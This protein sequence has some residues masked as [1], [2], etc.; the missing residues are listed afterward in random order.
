MQMTRANRRWLR[1][2]IAAGV[3]VALV[4]VA[5][6]VL[7]RMIRTKSVAALAN[8]CGPRS[9]VTMSAMEVNV[10]AGDL[11]WTRVRVEQPT[12]SLFAADD[13][14]AF[15]IAGTIDTVAIEG[16]SLFRLIF[17]RSFVARSLRI[18]HPDLHV[19]LRNDTVLE[20]ATSAG[21]RALS[22]LRIM[23]LEID[24]G[25]LHVFRKGDQGTVLNVDQFA[26]QATGAIADFEEGNAPL[27]QF[28]T[29]TGE[30]SDFAA[31]LS[32]LYDMRVA[33]V[34]LS[35]GGS[36][37][38]VIGAALEPLAGPENYGKLVPFETDLI[39]MHAD[40]LLAQGLDINAS[41]AQRGLKS[42]KLLMAGVRGEVHRDKTL[43]DAPYSKKR[44]PM[45][46]LRNLP[47]TLDVDSVQMERLRVHYHERGDLGPDYGEVLFSGI[48]GTITGLHSADTLGGNEVHMV[49]QA[50]AYDQAL[51][52]VDARTSMNAPN[53]QFTLS[54]TISAVPIEVFN[55]MTTDLVAVR[56]TAGRINNV[57]Y[58]L[59]GNDDHATGRVDV[60][61][62]DLAV[63][64]L[65]HDGS[66]DVD[67]F[68]TSVIN[69]VVRSENLR[70]S[71]GFRH[72]DFAIDREQDR[73]V[74]KYVWT[75][76]REGMLAAMLPGVLDDLR[77][78]NKGGPRKKR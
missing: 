71:D 54:A 30:V 75:G 72:G 66:G 24:G 61:Y 73:A 29:I 21:E 23:A 47:F 11:R 8:F 7:E 68:K 31:G 36:Q 33:C 5:Q 14:R 51:V 25:A 37:L 28:V 48:S 55:R 40:T 58:R 60:S 39:A 32:P 78:S 50:Q 69:L 67:R 13:A 49:A 57:N 46:G 27:L 1:I 76:L 12:D 38:L 42:M 64:A 2:T 44:L 10:L 4:F 3:L 16:L 18:S 43:P 63:S 19:Q 74:F 52:T 70:S 26:L 35:R 59:T 62:Q 9:T 34:D 15:H 53:E 77:K 20:E 41:I 45:A 65:K 22:A 6:Y 17:G 56:T